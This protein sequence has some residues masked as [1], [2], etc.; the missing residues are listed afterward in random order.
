[1]V[2]TRFMVF[3]VLQFRLWLMRWFVGSAGL[4]LEKAI[5]Q[6]GKPKLLAAFAALQVLNDFFH[7]G[8]PSELLFGICWI[9]ITH[10]FLLVMQDV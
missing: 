2:S 8:G 10:Q 9:C 1:M 3:Q 4:Q 6:G 7:E 5:S